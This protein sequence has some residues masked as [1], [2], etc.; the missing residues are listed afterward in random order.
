[1]Y[2]M[3]TFNNQLAFNLWNIC[4]VTF[5]TYYSWSYKFRK[6]NVS[7]DLHDG[8]HTAPF[9]GTSQLGLFD[10]AQDVVPVVFLPFGI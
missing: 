9:R 6:K 1:M 8:V 7:K 10:A 3:F 2:S 4:Q 5:S